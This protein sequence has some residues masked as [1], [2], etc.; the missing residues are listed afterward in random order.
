[1]TN[2]TTN[3][4]SGLGHGPALH[5]AADVTGRVVFPLACFIATTCNALIIVTLNNMGVDRCAKVHMILVAAMDIVQA[6]GLI[7]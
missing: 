5:V 4:S 2:L 7:G 1:M 6:I 3:T